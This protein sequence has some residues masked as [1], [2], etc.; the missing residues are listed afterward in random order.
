MARI[1]L[2][3]G[4]AV[5]LI[6]CTDSVQ[7]YFA[8]TEVSH[9]RIQ[10]TRGQVVWAEGQSANAIGQLHGAPTSRL[11]TFF[12]ISPDA[13]GDG[14]ESAGEDSGGS[15]AT[16]DLTDGLPPGKVDSDVKW[17]KRTDIVKIEGDEYQRSRGSL[18]VIVKS[19]EGLATVWQLT[20][21]KDIVKSKDVLT[22]AKHELR[23]AKSVQSA[24][25]AY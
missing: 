13:T 20:P 4:F 7:S 14:S 25:A 1:L 6:S 17:D 16:F 5:C 12:F 23:D 21:R 24:L 19:R 2:F 10:G 3:A 9:E 11:L 18:F 22:F 15:V 8:I